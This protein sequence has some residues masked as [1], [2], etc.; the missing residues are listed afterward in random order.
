MFAIYAR[1]SIE[2]Q[3]SV[4]I[5]TQIEQCKN[6]I[7][8]KDIKVYSDVGYSGKNIKRPQF[9]QLL[10]DVERG[11]VNTV[12]SYRLDRVSR[13]ITD[14]ANLLQLFEKHNVQYISATEQFDTTSP[15]GRAMIYIVMVFAQLERET[16]ATRIVDNYRYRAKLGYFMGGNTPF[17]YSSNRIVIDGKKASVLMPNEDGV[18]LKKI[19]DLFT[20]RNSL[21]SMA[22]TLN[23]DGYR[24][25]KG[26]LWTSNSI[27]RILEN[28]SP[29]CADEKMYNY[30]YSKGYEI[31]NNKEDFDGQF[32]MCLFF[33][34][35]NRNQENN[36][37]KQV[38]VIGLHKPTI[39]SDQFIK[40]QAILNSN[41][42]KHTKRSQKS[43]LA[44]L[45]KCNDCGFSF[46][47]KTTTKSDKEYAYYYCRGRHSRG[48]CQNSIYIPADELE[49]IILKDCIKHINNFLESD[50]KNTKL[51][52][53][54]F[55]KESDVQS[56]I[57]NLISNI[58][59]GNTIVDN[60]LTSK[61]T[62]LQSQ[63]EEFKADRKKQYT[64]INFEDIKA[65][66][67]QLKA[68]N[69]ISINDKTALIRSIV[70]SASVTSDG[71][72][73]VIYNF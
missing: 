33:K 71:D 2:R 66:K 9:E 69:K 40:T 53:S 59:K 44:G 42:P 6:R 64:E 8:E 52:Q 4:S 43:F 41:E 20:D 68:F 17:G 55:T 72:V 67:R 12:V 61:I 49:L 24:T 30:L 63:L 70:K 31:A 21:Q 3:D 22:K 65:M 15:M 62:A 57:D 10:K 73:M 48:L 29:C 27:K 32:G 28:I 25:A 58:G 50:L 14:F 34:N 7:S 13:S 18:I 60:L 23:I 16:I 45:L 54:D 19:F 36:I 56:Q 38:A 37:E 26:K 51:K 11:L 1:Q 5:E 39:S 35:K 47:L 46:G